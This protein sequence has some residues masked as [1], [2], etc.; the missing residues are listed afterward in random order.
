MITSDVD[1]YAYT[2]KILRRKTSKYVD[3]HVEQK[4]H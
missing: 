1:E 4:Q 3:T 2:S